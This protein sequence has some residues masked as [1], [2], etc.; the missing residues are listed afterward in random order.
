MQIVVIGKA[1]EIYTQLSLEQRKYKKLFLKFMSWSPRITGTY[2]KIAE[3]SM[4]RLMLN[5]LEL[6]VN[7]LI[8]GFLERKLALVMQNSDRPCLLKNCNGA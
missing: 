1:R 3:K 5:L 6:N 2:L 7:Y 4:T 8:S